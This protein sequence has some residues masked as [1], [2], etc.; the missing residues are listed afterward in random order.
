MR[1]KRQGF[2]Q[3]TT[4][5]KILDCSDDF[6][7]KQIRDGNLEAIRVGKRATRISEASL[8]RFI[9]ERKVNPDDYFL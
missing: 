4:A 9:A 8:D 5:A 2:I 7:R 6:I 3:I 1:T